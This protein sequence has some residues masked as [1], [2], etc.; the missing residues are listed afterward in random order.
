MTPPSRPSILAAMRKKGNMV[1]HR[2]NTGERQSSGFGLR[3]INYALL[4]G[5]EVA[6]VS[7]YVLLDRG[8]I[9]AAPILLV[10]GYIVLIPA[11]LLV[12]LRE[13]RN[14]G[15]SGDD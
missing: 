2:G 4:G 11:A 5:A 13:R 7:G 6:I 9:T 12:G 14:G 3:P 10:F 8:S 1:G 15:A